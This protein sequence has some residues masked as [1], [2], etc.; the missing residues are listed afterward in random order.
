MEMGSQDLL[1]AGAEAAP[2]PAN[3]VS[4][5]TVALYGILAALT[6]AITYASFAPF[7]PT[8]GYF[9]LGDSMVFFSALAFGCRAGAICGGV[10][11]AAADVLLGFGIFA[12]VTLVAKGGEG[13]VAGVISR[14]GKGKQWAVVLGIAA[15]GAL[16]ITTYFFAEWLFLDVGFGKALAEIPINIGQVAFG[17]TIGAGLTHM[18]RKSYPTL[19][20]GQ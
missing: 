9:N 10:G 11:S 7:S 2:K 17:G 20:R 8:K 16:M 18:I 4:P 12:P 6:T 3:Y 15:G 19:I 13:F 14:S 1:E 5:R